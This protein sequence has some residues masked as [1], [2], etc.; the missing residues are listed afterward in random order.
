MRHVGCLVAACKL[1]VAAGGIY[2]LTRDQPR[3][4]ALGVLSLSH[5]TA[6][7]V[8]S[9]LELENLGVTLWDL[10][11]K[12]KYNFPDASFLSVTELSITP[13]GHEE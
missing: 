4:P 1:L 8:P 2:S 6:S 7:E 5:W 11:L 9:L 3:P 10:Y 13:L 12:K